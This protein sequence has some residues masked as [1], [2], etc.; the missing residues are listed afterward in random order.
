MSLEHLRHRR[1]HLLRLAQEVLAR[2]ALGLGGIG[3]QLDPVD[4]EHLPADQPLAVTHREHLGEDR[5]E[6]FAQ[7]G[8]EGGERGEVRRAVAGDGHE[9]HVA[10]TGGFD[11]PRAHDSA[12]VGEQHDLE[13]HGG[14]VGRGAARVVAEPRFERRQIDF[15]RIDQEAQ[16]VFE[17][18]GDDL[19][20]EI[21]RNKLQA[22]VRLL[23]P[24]HRRLPT[25]DARLSHRH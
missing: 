7:F 6:R 19:L 9:Q 22:V 23:E 3:G 12:R 5:L 24:R 17:T 21:H 14:R 4:G 16:R 1:F 13:Q 2:A 20:D 11:L 18:A 25:A 15:A 10:A 8:D